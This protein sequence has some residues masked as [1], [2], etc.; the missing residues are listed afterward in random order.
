MKY[1]EVI[2]EQETLG[3]IEQVEDPESST[4]GR[5]HYLPH[6]AIVKNN[7]TTTKV[8]V[9]FDAS[10]K[11]NGP[12]LNECLHIGPRFNQ[13]IL[14]ILLKFRVHKVSLNRRH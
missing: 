7:N 14:D 10:A 5:I 9:V 11:L 6:H 12:S 1:I 13:K 2:R 4:G 8:R 3:I